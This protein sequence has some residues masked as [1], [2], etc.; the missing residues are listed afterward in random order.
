M[1]VRLLSSSAKS[2]MF[3][4]ASFEYSP[5]DAS[6]IAKALVAFSASL[7]SD[8]DLY[9]VARVARGPSKAATLPP[10]PFSDPPNE[11]KLL[12]ADL[13]DLTAEAPN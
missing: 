1:P 8:I 11:S 5:V 4:T 9:T 6:E 3:A 2:C 13:T 7:A 10:K 12:S